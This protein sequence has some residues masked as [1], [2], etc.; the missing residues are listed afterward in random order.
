[1]E[2]GL[3]R[4]QGHTELVGITGKRR[5]LPDSIGGEAQG[6]DPHRVLYSAKL[7]V[8]GQSRG[9][10]RCSDYGPRIRMCQG[11]AQHLNESADARLDC[12]RVGEFKC[13]VVFTTGFGR[14]HNRQNEQ[15]GVFLEGVKA[16]VAR[17]LGV[18]RQISARADEFRDAH[19]HERAGR[20]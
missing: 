14:I 13:N 5:R 18:G 17:R 16:K 4:R 20:K 19:G 10:L 9:S 12:C 11:L 3:V 6:I 7:A 15:A 1:M 2:V 8:H